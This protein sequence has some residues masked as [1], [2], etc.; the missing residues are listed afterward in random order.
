MERR[1]F[2]AST[3]AASALAATAERAGAQDA[4]AE[5]NSNQREFYLLRRYLVSAGPQR[6]LTDAYFRDALVP[7]LN[8]LEFNPIGVFNETI[9]AEM[10]VMYVLIPSFSLEKL[11]TVDERLRK[12]EEYLK[13]AAPFLNAPGKEPAFKRMESSLMQA[14]EKMP[15]LILPPAS[16]SRGPRV[17]ELRMYE[18]PSDLDHR[19]KIKQ[20]SSGEVDIFTKVGMPQV[21]YGD[22]LVGDR[23]PNLMYMV[24]FDSLAERDQKWSAFF[25]SP[26]WKTLSSDPRF[27]YENIVSNTSNAMLAPMPYS[28]I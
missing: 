9:G 5:T 18:G 3:F 26:G 17:F 14:F 1:Q 23:M 2:L 4:R 20:M 15:R 22:T 11:V 19:R 25:S 12:D 21:F 6:V 13:A 27:T 28:Q 16:V 24:C 10:P 8:R 7:A